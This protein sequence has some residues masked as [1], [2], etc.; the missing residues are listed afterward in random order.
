M[1]VNCVEKV[2]T[3]AQAGIPD[4]S[5]AYSSVELGRHWKSG[6]APA[7]RKSVFLPPLHLP[8]TVADGGM[9]QEGPE[10]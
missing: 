1:V 4:Q 10:L 8:F 6:L 2:L 7:N 5:N 9:F 3:L